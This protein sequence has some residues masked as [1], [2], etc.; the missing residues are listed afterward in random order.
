M[1]K[2]MNKIFLVMLV[3]MMLLTG[4]NNE[5]INNE[6]GT[7]KVVTTI[8]PSFDFARAIG[9]DN[10]SLSMLIK[11]GGET[12]SYEPSPKDITDIQNS[13]LFIYVGGEGE[14]WVETILESMDTSE[15]TIVRL[16]DYV[17]VV[18]EEIVEGMEHDHEDHE[19][20]DHDHSEEEHHEDEH[21][22]DEHIWTSPV[23][24]MMLVEKITEVLVSI[25]PENKETY[26]ANRDA[27]IS[28][29]N[30]VHEEFKLVV[31]EA[32]RDTLVFADRFP[33]RYFVEE[34]GLKYSAAFPGC[35]T[36][37]EPSAKT[38]AYLIDKVKL[39]NIPV[40]FYIEF[41]NQKM[42]DTII[43]ETGAT[44]LEFHS[45]HNVSLED[46]NAGK[47]YV[48]IMRQNINNLKEA[49]K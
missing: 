15:M 16:M 26:E 46:F 33:F 14:R 34:Y 11:P 35:A 32:N 29:I 49:I 17:N 47:T 25:D 24:A 8:F 9:V 3:L 10:V 12:H 28:E 44:K 38:V 41:S 18:E 37:T 31:I 1:R 19:H 42:A 5:N 39:E 2:N 22:Y 7:L 30:S 36:E 20:E 23:N 4:C 27:Y 21:A 13:D 43:E 48:D 45:A 6:D 40:V